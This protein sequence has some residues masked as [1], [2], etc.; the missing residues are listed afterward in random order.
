MS[1][2]LSAA[3]LV[4][5]IKILPERVDEI[6]SDL[7]R[8]ALKS[9][10]QN[11]AAAIS[12]LAH[13]TAQITHSPKAIL[14]LAQKCFSS[15]SSIAKTTNYGFE[16]GNKNENG[17]FQT[18][19]NPAPH[20]R[21]RTVVTDIQAAR[22]QRCLVVLGYICEKSR[23]C[24]EIFKSSQHQNIENSDD[25]DDNNGDN[26]GDNDSR[27]G[28]KNRGNIKGN[29]PGSSSGPR[30]KFLSEEETA[31]TYI[32]DIST[33]TER[34]LNGCCYSASVFALSVPMPQV[35]ARAVQCLCGVFVGE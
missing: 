10:G 16:N 2:I 21:A 1:E 19:Q 8:I 32:C 35:Q 29:H 12:C 7:S 13:I 15:I 26:D 14:N 4:D 5:G 18:G 31:V 3:T 11:T 27:N 30:T 33:V 24:S 34:N 20:V 6:I 23:K 25:N 22:V 28:G 17:N 9:N